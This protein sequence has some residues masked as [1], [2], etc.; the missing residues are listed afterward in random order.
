MSKENF[1]LELDTRGMLFAYFDEHDRK[2]YV[3]KRGVET[4]G[5]S[6][7]EIFHEFYS[8][9]AGE[10]LEFHNNDPVSIERG[11]VFSSTRADFP[12]DYKIVEDAHEEEGTNL[13]VR[14]GQHVLANEG[15]DTSDWDKMVH[16]QP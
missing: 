14:F 12:N 5:L 10:A 11:W 13:Y 7:R 6:D 4:L 16:Y 8:L 3:A 9:L 2:A 15:M 1:Y